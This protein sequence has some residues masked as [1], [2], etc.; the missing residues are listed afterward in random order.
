[1][2]D[3]LKSM[4]DEI[5]EE[6]LVE[7]EAMARALL[8]KAEDMGLDS[9]SISWTRGEKQQERVYYWNRPGLETLEL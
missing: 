9:M 2:E 7:L 3:Q 8:A 5:Q 1:M 6:Q 4:F